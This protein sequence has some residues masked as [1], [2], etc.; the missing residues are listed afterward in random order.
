MRR[1]ASSGR[2]ITHRGASDMEGEGV[3]P[4]DVR[5]EQV[6]ASLKASLDEV[7]GTDVQRLDTSE[8]VRIEEVLAIASQAAKGVVSIRRQRRQGKRPRTSGA[9]VAPLIARGNAPMG[10]AAVGAHRLFLDERG[11][12]WDAFA[13]MPTTE[14]RGLARLPEQYQQGWLCFESATE[15]RRLGPIPA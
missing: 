5:L 9:T 7:C 3:R 11:V 1:S 14:P 2:R 15:K 12:L 8:A 6:T 10:D 4:L 13:V